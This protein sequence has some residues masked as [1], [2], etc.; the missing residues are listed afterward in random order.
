MLALEPNADL[1][2]FREL[3]A[4]AADAEST[5]K[6]LLQKLRDSPETGALH[7]YALAVLPPEA[8]AGVIAE[9]TGELAVCS[10]ALLHKVDPE[11]GRTLDRVLRQDPCCVYAVKQFDAAIRR[12]QDETDEEGGGESHQ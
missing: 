11:A 6:D 8:A 2:E 12:A 10:M 1:G 9:M 7:V 4:A 5:C 3:R